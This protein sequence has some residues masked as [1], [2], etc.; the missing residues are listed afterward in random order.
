MKPEEE[1]KE[2]NMNARCLV[3]GARDGVIDIDVGIP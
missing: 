1:F 3:E 2:T